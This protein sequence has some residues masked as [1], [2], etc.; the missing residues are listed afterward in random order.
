MVAPALQSEVWERR[1]GRGI[2]TFHPRHN[3]VPS[4][5][6]TAQP[7]QGG[8]LCQGCWTTIAPP[9]PQAHTPAPQGCS[10]VEAAPSSVHRCLTKLHAN[11]CE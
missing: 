3:C 2:C 10:Y 7:L 4:V 8:Q 6:C 9:L 11:D 5:I 1:C